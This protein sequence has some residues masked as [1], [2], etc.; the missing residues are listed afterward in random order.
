V[1]VRGAQ[2]G[3][4][5]VHQQALQYCR[6]DPE[7]VVGGGAATYNTQEVNKSVYDAAFTHTFSKACFVYKE[8]SNTVGTHTRQSSVAQGPKALTH[9][10]LQILLLDSHSA[11]RLH[12]AQTLTHLTRRPAP[13]TAASRSAEWR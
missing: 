6:G 9:G 4:V 10:T 5:A 12:S 2:H 8:R 7:S 1:E 13:A 11:I 3:G